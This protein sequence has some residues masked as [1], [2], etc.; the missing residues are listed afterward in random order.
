MKLYTFGAFMGLQLFASSIP[1]AGFDWGELIKAGGVAAICAFVLVRLE[2]RLRGVEKSIDR[3]ARA[4]VIMIS[5]LPH[6]IVAVQ[7]QCKT[8]QGEL[9]RAAIERGENPNSP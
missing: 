7:L 1:S 2:P 4:M 6:V 8:L 3:L 5:E 9:D